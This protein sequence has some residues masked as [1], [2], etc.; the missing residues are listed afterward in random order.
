MSAGQGYYRVKTQLLCCSAIGAVMLGS[1]AIAHANANEGDSIDSI[2]VT[3]QKRAERLEDV[4]VALSAL[5]E[6]RIEA[7]SAERLSDLQNFVPNLAIESDNAFVATV[8]IRGVGDYSRNIGYDTRVGV[9]LDGVYLGQSPAVDQE[10]VELER[11]EVMRGPQGALF[12]K[13]TVAGAINLISKKPSYEFEG[14]LSANIG[15]LDY[16]QFSGHVNVPLNETVAVRLSANKI[17]RDGFIENLFSPG[18]K[19]GNRDGLSYRAQ[20]RA[21]VSEQFSVTASFDGSHKEEIGDYGDPVSG[22]FGAVLETVASPLTAAPLPYQESK[23]EFRGENV[24]ILGGSVAANYDFANDFSINSVT[25]FRTTDFRTIFD[26]DHSAADILNTDF[27]DKYNQLTQETQLISPQGGELE[28]ILGVYYFRQKATT[29]RSA[30]AGSDGLFLGPPVPVAGELLTN[31]VAIFGNLTYDILDNLE[32]GLGFRLSREKKTVDWSIDGGGGPLFATG[33]FQDSRVDNDFSP[34][35]TLTY[36]VSPDL[37][38]YARFAEGYK[39]GGYN[40]DFVSPVVFPSRI[41]FD[42]ETVRNYEVGMKGSFFD[43]LASV[44]V[45]AFWTEYKDYQVNQLVDL[46]GGQ[47]DFIIGNAPAR[48]RGVEFEATLRPTSDLQL[49]GSLGYLDPEYGDFPGGGAGGAD[50]TGNRLTYASKIQA[51][52]AIDFNRDITDALNFSANISYAYRGD[53]F[54]TTDNVKEQALLAGGVVPFGFVPSYDLLSGRVAIAGTNDVWEVA[55][56]ARNILDSD[57]IENTRREFLGAVL[58]YYAEPRVFGVE[59]KVS[60]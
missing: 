37:N 38:V 18:V 44:L 36:N 35:A 40:I 23:N 21:D 48:T 54:T 25:A 22:P 34:V 42:K 31:S 13:N 20:V 16:R 28:Y 12:G 57:H 11:V 46:G 58:D 33:E 47:S 41:E 59:T 60:F 56:W 5:G 9:Y 50:V 49:S 2:V 26:V 53:Y 1:S 43:K 29:S 30:I 55:L 17:D 10:L 45:S 14:A 52:A 6:A 7:A 19:I 3:A 15:N 51:S 4:P 8:R 27:Q 39:S 32:L 24:D